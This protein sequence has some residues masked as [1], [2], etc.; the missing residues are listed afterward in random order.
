MSSGSEKKAEMLDQIETDL[1]STAYVIITLPNK[2][3]SILVAN[4][5]SLAE[6]LDAY[7]NDGRPGSAHHVAHDRKGTG[8]NCVYFYQ[9]IPP[10]LRNVLTKKQAYILESKSGISEAKKADKM[11]MDYLGMRV[12]ELAHKPEPSILPMSSIIPA[13][14]ASK[15]V[16]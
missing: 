2:S 3:G 14:D 4:N 11:A 7:I 5:T 13:I 6:Q 10:D 9:G 15:H 8:I 16:G 12:K 1:A